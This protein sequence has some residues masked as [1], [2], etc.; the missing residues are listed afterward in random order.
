MSKIYGQSDDNV[1]LEGEYNG[2]YS[3]YFKAEKGFMFFFDDGTILKIRYGELGIWKIELIH[4]GHLF[5]DI[6]YCND[7]DAEI[8]SDIVY[9]KK[10][11]KKVYACSKWEVVR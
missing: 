10:G 3:N 8:Y 1:Y 7:P 9:F 2:Q 11:L 4:L 5:D 6:E